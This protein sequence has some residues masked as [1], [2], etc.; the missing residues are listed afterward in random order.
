MSVAP[1]SRLGPYE[2]LAPLGA[3]GMGEVY[4]ARDGRLG[5]EVAIKVLPAELAGDAER[6]ERFEREARAA[7]ALNHP[8]ILAV[9]DLGT[10]EGAPFLVCELLE[11]ETLRDRLRA[12]RP[13]PAAALGWALQLARGIAAAHARGVVHRDLKPENLFLTRDGH[14]K[15]L[16][17]GLAKVS[18]PATVAA[19]AP[20]VAGT[21][22]GTLLG[23]AGYMAP[24]QA[25]GLPAD[26]RSD[27]FAFG[28]VV[29]ELL[30][31]ESAFQRET[32][33]DTLAAVLREEPRELA[34]TPLG[35]PPEVVRLVRRCLAK[36]PEDRYQSAADLAFDLETLAAAPRAA[37][38][39]AATASVAVLPF[40]DLSPGRDQEY[41]CD[42]V[43]EEILNA[44]CCVAGLRVAART[45]S[46]QFRHVALDVRAIGQRLGVTHVLEGSVRKAGDRLRVT[47][48]LVEVDGG[49]HLW[50]ER[51]DRG[52]ADV[53]EIQDE[54]AQK[55]ALALRGVLS[56]ALRRGQRQAATRNVEA[57]DYYLRGRQFFYQARRRG[58]EYAR[59][60]FERALALDPGY[61]LAWAGLADCSSWLAPWW[62]NDPEEIR[63]GEEASRR[64]VEL[65]P[66]LAETH[67]SRGQSLVLA[68]RFAEAE[69]EFQTALRLQPGLFEALYFYARAC[70]AQGRLAGVGGPLRA[71]GGS[72]PGGL[73][74]AAPGDLGPRRPRPAGRGR[75]GD[76]PR[77]G[78]G[79][80]LPRAPSRRLPRLLPG[81]RGAGAPGLARGGPGARRA[82]ALDRPRRAGGALQPGLRLR[83]RRPAGARAR[84]PRAGGWAALRAQGLDRPRPR[85]RLPARHPALRGRAGAARLGEKKTAGPRARRN[86]RSARPTRGRPT[87]SYGRPSSQC[88]GSVAQSPALTRI[89]TSPLWTVAPSSAS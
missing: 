44:L 10:H 8:N 36:R 87:L 51:Y 67:A 25:R 20:T 58:M 66:G 2:V 3:G 46:F 6:L 79:P 52:L 29:Y 64:A 17:F 70:F 81:R 75:G 37:P 24:E 45:S 40:S 84:L 49:Y 77:R 50:S 39:A 7:A 13:A 69:E 11:G 35:L 30:A 73:P 80:A 32:A 76:A 57:Y 47:V 82:G 31:G 9:H 88:V 86:H 74:V 61:A 55:V 62:G 15:I 14:L 41:F 1:G 63:R 26:A 19:T 89:D 68:R 23:T 34:A 5:R 42:G 28:A 60:M 53:F 78:P 72:A 65:A 12:G 48:Q 33:A 16:D 56:E 22:A 27:I 71:G 54:I 43:A 4:R 18:A 85:P 59:Q 21:L 38:E 83:P